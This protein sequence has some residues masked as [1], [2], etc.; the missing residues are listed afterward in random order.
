MRD[1]LNKLRNP[2]VR[3]RIRARLRWWFNDHF[4]ERIGD[5]ILVVEVITTSLTIGFAHFGFPGCAILAGLLGLFLEHQLR[6]RQRDL[7]IDEAAKRGA[8]EAAENISD[9]MRSYGLE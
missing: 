9:A 6:D 1:T 2:T 7:D 8:Q 4:E 3:Q 5:Y